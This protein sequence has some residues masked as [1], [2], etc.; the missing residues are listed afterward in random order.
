MNK[1]GV[2][3]ITAAQFLP[4]NLLEEHPE[5][6][7]EL[8]RCLAGYIGEEIKKHHPGEFTTLEE[9][10]DTNAFQTEYRMQVYLISPEK[11]NYYRTCEELCEKYGIRTKLLEVKNVR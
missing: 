4:M 10:A 1:N 11:L 5:A 8:I 9:K 7:E 6:K 3:K 2:V